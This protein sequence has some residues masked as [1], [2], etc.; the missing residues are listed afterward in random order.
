MA[1]GKRNPVAQLL[2]GVKR[3][4]IQGLDRVYYHRKKLTAA[5]TENE[6]DFFSAQ[7]GET[8][9]LMYPRMDGK[10]DRGTRFLIQEFGVHLD[11]SWGKADK[12]LFDDAIFEIHVEDGEGDRVKFRAPLIVA[13]SGVGLVG[14]GA[15]VAAA[16]GAVAEGTVTNGHAD[17]RMFRLQQP[18]MIEEQVTW[19]ARVAW[20]SAP[21]WST[22][23]GDGFATTFLRGIEGK[24]LKT[25]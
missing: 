12:V 24:K 18:L 8:D 7:G 21:D 23:T 19:K 5:S 22:L 9:Y 2:R 16:A 25:G 13:R 14:S 11:D 4:A 6:L 10:L 17:G 3:R 15:V 20:A 1:R